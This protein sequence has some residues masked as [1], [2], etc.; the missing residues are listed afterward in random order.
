MTESEFQSQVIDLAARLGWLHYHTH[1]SRKSDSGYPD[2]TLVRGNRLVY[3]ELKS[4]DGKVNGPQR[5]WLEAL[6]RTNAEVYIWRPEDFDQIEKVLTS[7]TAPRD[8]PEI[9]I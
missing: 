1:D 9:N 3:A 7:W 5:M 2:L 8:I 4:A 6:S